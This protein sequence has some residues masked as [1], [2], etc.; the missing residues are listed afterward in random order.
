MMGTRTTKGLI[1]LSLLA[2]GLRLAAVRLLWF[3][4]SRPV[5]FE[6]GEIAE[7]LLAGKG[8]SIRFLGQEGPT[9]QQAPF[10]PFL[11]AGF[12]AV[13]GPGT[14]QSL[15][16]VQL[17][18]CV[19][20]LLIVLLVVRLAWQVVP[21][22]REIGWIAGAGAAVY[23]PHVYMV[24]HLQVAP[25]AAM[26][27]V[28]TLGV[29]TSDWAYR[30]RLGP[31]AAGLL[32]GWMLLVDPILALPLGVCA[33]VMLIRREPPGVAYHPRR[34]E[35]PG[36]DPSAVAVAHNGGWE[37]ASRAATVLAVALAIT[38]PWTVRNWM[39]YGELV[40][41]KSTFW[42]AFWQGNNPAS[43]G[44]DK[45]PKPT[46]EILRHEH[47]GTLAGLNRALWEARH[48]TVYIDDVLLKPG[49]YAG[50][51]G[52]SEPERCRELGRR[53]LQFVRE[54]P[55]RYLRLC[56]LRLRYW[57]LFDE[58][59]PKA[60][61]WLYRL[62]TVVLLVLGTAGLVLSWRYRNT[63][64]PTYTIFLLLTVFHALVIVSV[65]FRIPA[66]PLAFLWAAFPVAALMERR[67]VCCQ[68]GE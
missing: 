38:V 60:A 46:A 24:T 42:Y 7:N 54:Q 9:S 12:Y 6:H 1:L 29:A 59:N 31:V 41:I 16:A 62:S 13:L 36:Q 44:T 32:G 18:Q 5:A 10:Y 66:E 30:T 19:V 68:S 22:R 15:I 26:L 64:W 14:A 37:R 28:A 58:T 55:G 61:H 2:L 35:A 17:L 51:I 45:I 52:L 33:A 65:R 49:G 23:P 57:L 53:A 21:Q 67:R 48:E 27:V 56:L 8:F 34:G 40:F 39:V 11:L 20:G 63:L 43:W 4:S 3:D 47:D 25:W 50:L